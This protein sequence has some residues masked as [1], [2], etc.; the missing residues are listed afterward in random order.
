VK[1]RI[2]GLLAVCLLAGPMP[3]RAVVILDQDNMQLFLDEFSSFTALDNSPFGRSQTFTVGVSGILDS[4]DIVVFG[5]MPLVSIRIIDTSGAVPIG[6]AVGSAV[7]AVST[8]FSELGNNIFR[9]DLSNANLHVNVG[10]VLAIE[11]IATNFDREVGWWRSLDGYSGGSD[12]FFNAEFDFDSWTMNPTPRD[13]AFRTFVDTTQQVPEPG[14]LA[15]LGL[16]LL[17]LGV[18]RRRA[19]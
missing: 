6:G 15:L 16:G 4:V 12:F 10:D 1:S 18:T 3:A 2:L 11:P 17:G 14:T 8:V 5:A 7:L 13:S 19:N 9:F